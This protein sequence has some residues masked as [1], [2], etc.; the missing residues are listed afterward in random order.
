ELV[1]TV[2]ASLFVGN[3]LLLVLNVP[4]VSLWTRILAIPYSILRAIIFA[5]I[6]IG[7]YA[8]ANSV[9]DVYIMIFF[10]ILGFVFRQV[11]VPLAPLVLTLILGPFLESSLRESLQLSQGSFTVFV[12]RPLSLVFL[13]LALGIVIASA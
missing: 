11:G 3:L 1:W 5:F 8:V 10:G 12:D 4:L 9:I 7:S 13:I 6:I 2:I